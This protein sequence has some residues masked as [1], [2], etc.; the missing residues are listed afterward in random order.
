MSFSVLPPGTIPVSPHSSHRM[1]MHNEYSSG[2]TSCATSPS[3]S[4]S[5]GSYVCTTQ[6]P[7]L[8]GHEKEQGICGA[9]DQS[10]RPVGF[11]F[12]LSNS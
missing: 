6:F 9:A 5:L 7:F 12:W 8:I 10:E 2:Q 11:H 3:S 4:G 1:G